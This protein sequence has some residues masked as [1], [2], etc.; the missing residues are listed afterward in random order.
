M[1]VIMT[2]VLTTPVTTTLVFTM[3]NDASY[4]GIYLVLHTDVFFS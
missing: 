3:R 2:P 4:N 1:P